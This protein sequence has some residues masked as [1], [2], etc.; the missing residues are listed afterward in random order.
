[1]ITI[2]NTNENNEVAYQTADAAGFDICA[3]E[4]VEIAPGECKAV[5]TGLFLENE[6]GENIILDYRGFPTPE[7]EELQIRPRSGLAFK[8][9]VTVCNSPGTVDYD[10]V[11]PNEI[12]VL[13]INHGKNTF[14]VKTGD[15]IAQGVV[16]R[17]VRAAGVK[18][19]SVQRQG[20]FGSTGK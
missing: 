11:A 18:V 1:M 8:H 12:K 9:S 2:K 4:D 3:N 7:Y 20:G 10:F 19:K 6:P 17:V 15:R 5:A 16:N 14:V 13:L